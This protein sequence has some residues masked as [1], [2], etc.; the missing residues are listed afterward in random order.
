[1]LSAVWN[2]YPHK[3]LLCYQMCGT[4]TLIKSYDIISCVGQVPSQR[5]MMLSDVR[6]KYPHKELR[7]YQLC[8]TS[9]LTKSY[10]IISCVGQVSS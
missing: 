2:K 6:D 5:A 9:T 4:S 3:E 7:Y 8:G 1:M 10:D